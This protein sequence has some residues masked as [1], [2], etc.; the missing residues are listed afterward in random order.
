MTWLHRFLR[1]VDKT[2][3]PEIKDLEKKNEQ[4]KKE[5]EELGVE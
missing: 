4:I 1:A 5:M 2:K 3:L